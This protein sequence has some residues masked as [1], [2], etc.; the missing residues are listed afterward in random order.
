MKKIHPQNSER[1]GN[2]KSTPKIGNERI[3][4]LGT[5]E[6]LTLV[7]ALRSRRSR[8]LIGDFLLSLSD[9]S[10]VGNVIDHGKTSSQTKH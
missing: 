9:F 10:L 8:S 7:Q 5:E 1:E 4:F 6:G 2:K 3:L